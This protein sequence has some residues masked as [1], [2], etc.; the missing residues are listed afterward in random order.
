MQ[1]VLKIAV[2]STEVRIQIRSFL[3]YGQVVSVESHFQSF[4]G[5]GVDQ[6]AEIIRYGHTSQFQERAAECIGEQLAFTGTYDSTVRVVLCP[7]LNVDC[8]FVFLVYTG[9]ADDISVD[10]V[11]YFTA[12]DIDTFRNIDGLSSV[13]IFLR[14]YMVDFGCFPPH[15]IF[16]VVV[17]INVPPIAPS[18][19]TFTVK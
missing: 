8:C 16:W 1:T 2:G 14:R 10:I 12:Y 17:E 18:M 13:F 19:S 9:I 5:V 15:H 3:Q 11:G 6:M 4:D 7:G